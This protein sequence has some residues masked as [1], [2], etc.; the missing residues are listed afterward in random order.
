MHSFPA[1]CILA[2]DKRL[3]CLDDAADHSDAK[4]L[5]ANLEQVMQ[6]FDDSAQ[7]REFMILA[8]SPKLSSVYKRH[9]ICAD[10]VRE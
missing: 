6:C 10:A 4:K 3:G 9:R 7:P 1:V 2:Y 8:M 5:V